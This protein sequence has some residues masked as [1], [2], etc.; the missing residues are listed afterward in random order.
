MKPNSTSAKR[1]PGSTTRIAE[2]TKYVA[3][4][5]GLEAR[6][7]ID[8]H[9]WQLVVIVIFDRRRFA[10][11]QPMDRAERDS[12]PRPLEQADGRCRTRPALAAAAIRAVLSRVE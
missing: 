10:S 12:D 9:Q 11:G 6:A 5:R 2:T 1:L 7:G 4:Q 3:E 8:R